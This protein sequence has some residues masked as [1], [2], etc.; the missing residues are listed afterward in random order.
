MQ[1]ICPVSVTCKHYLSH[2]YWE[3]ICLC[4]IVFQRPRGITSSKRVGHASHYNPGGIASYAAVPGPITT[5]SKLTSTA[6]ACMSCMGGPYATLQSLASANMWQR[7]L[8]CYIATFHNLSACV[9]LGLCIRS[10]VRK[11]MFQAATLSVT[12][13]PS[14]TFFSLSLYRGLFPETSTIRCEKF[15]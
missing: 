3:I 11:T 4:R 10:R 15:F 12:F 8:S 7:W 5:R 1:L 13:S 6:Q 14:T 2:V 9:I